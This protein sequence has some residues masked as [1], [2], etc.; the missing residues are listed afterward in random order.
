MKGGLKEG[1]EISLEKVVAV[2]CD[3]TALNLARIFKG[4][5]RGEL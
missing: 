4:T 2:L 1:I 5:P 3:I